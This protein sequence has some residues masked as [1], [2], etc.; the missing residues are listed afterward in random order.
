M[1]LDESGFLLQPVRRRTWAPR[2]QTPIQRAWDRH[3][4]LS[5]I[6]ALSL[7]PHNLRIGL[8]F[9]LLEHNVRTDDFVAF[10]K[11]LHRQLR[12]DLILVMDRYSVHR[13]GVRRL[14]E[15]GCRWLSVEWLPPY[16]PELN[17]VEFVWNHTKYSDLAN[18]VPDDVEQLHEAV[19]ESIDDQQQDAWLKRSF[20]RSAGLLV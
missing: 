11:Q 15:A 2:G 14:E 6:A 3:D 17:P 9:Q 20:F 16:A 7:A 19:L 10:V 4:R 12:R 1:F 13:S 18:F 8:Y 5:G